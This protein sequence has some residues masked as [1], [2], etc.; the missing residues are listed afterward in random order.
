MKV[1][2]DEPTL[3]LIGGGGHCR[4][5]LSLIHGTGRKALVFD[6]PSM[7]GSDVLG[8]LVAG[9]DAEL[10]R[11]DRK[12]HQFMV[13]VGST[14]ENFT[15]EKIFSRI[16]EMGFEPGTVIGKTAFIATGTEIGGGTAV[17][18]RA[19]INTG[20]VIGKNC[21]I[22]TG[23]IIEHDCCI[24]DHVHIAPGVTMSGGVK[25]GSGTFV[26]VGATVIQGISIGKNCVI[27]AGAVVIRDVPDHAFVAGVPAV[28]KKIPVR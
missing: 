13:T 3:L 24:A 23:A 7:V 18:E 26:G 1:I 9:T 27:A 16:V 14:K 11:Y 25:I 17:L 10:E 20:T 8:F 19:V 4:S 5:V 21:I 15:R 6:R 28:E 22:N 12:I 2:L